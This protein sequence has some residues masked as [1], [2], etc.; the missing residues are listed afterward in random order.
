M[1]C[2]LSRVLREW[3]QSARRDKDCAP[4]WK[5][6]RSCVLN[7]LKFTSI[8]SKVSC[9][10]IALFFLFL[11]EHNEFTAVRY[12]CKNLIRSSAGDWVL[13]ARAGNQAIF[14]YVIK[15]IFQTALS[16]RE[17]NLIR[18]VG[19]MYRA[20]KA[21]RTAGRGKLVYIHVV[22]VF[23]SLVQRNLYIAIITLI[24][25]QTFI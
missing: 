19:K 15:E 25:T 13:P 23:S 9:L 5:A 10:T 4:W 1:E 8:Q 14:T 2:F 11:W 18:T 21:T 7:I 16:E 6:S 20:K 12:G 3:N 17:R 24:E 22:V